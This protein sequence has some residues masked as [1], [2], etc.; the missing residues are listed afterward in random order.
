[1]APLLAFSLASKA[2]E[3]CRPWRASHDETRKRTCGV[4][5]DCHAN[6][7]DEVVLRILRHVERTPRS[8]DLADWVGE[9]GKPR[10]QSCSGWRLPSIYPDGATECL[11]VNRRAGL[12]PPSIRKAM[13]WNA[14][15][16]LDST[17]NTKHF[18]PSAGHTPMRLM[19]GL[20]L[21]LDPP[22]LG[23]RQSLRK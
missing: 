8:R 19:N 1:M 3:A 10:L 13:V 11:S 21:P 7:P 16:S 5:C 2:S 15:R 14:N 17:P 22:R 20:K 12:T 6:D 4:C 23:S 18:G 9:V